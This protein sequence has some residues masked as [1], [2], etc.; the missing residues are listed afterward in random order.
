MTPDRYQTAKEKAELFPIEPPGAL[1]A[2][3]LLADRWSR[4]QSRERNSL[5]ISAISRD[6]TAPFQT[7]PSKL[8]YRAEEIGPTSGI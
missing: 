7:A 2:S 5:N 4:C 8:R 3:E 1:N 6:P